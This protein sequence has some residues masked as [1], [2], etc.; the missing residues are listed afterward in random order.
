MIDYDYKLCTE[1]KKTLKF[2]VHE[3]S[4]GLILQQL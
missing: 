3:P 1:I 2:L 4:L